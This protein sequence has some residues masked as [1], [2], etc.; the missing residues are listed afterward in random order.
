MQEYVDCGVSVKA[1]HDMMRY[2]VFCARY[3][4]REK[5]IC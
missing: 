2:R 5:K 1:A 3:A 4:L